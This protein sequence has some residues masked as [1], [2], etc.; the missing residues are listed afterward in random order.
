MGD[1]VQSGD[2]IW[3]SPGDPFRLSCS[4]Q[5][6]EKPAKSQTPDRPT[7]RRHRGC[8]P[9]APSFCIF[10]SG[11]LLPFISNKQATLAKAHHSI[12]NSI[13]P[14]FATHLGTPGAIPQAK[15]GQ[16]YKATP[17]QSLL[18]VGRFAL[19]RLDLPGAASAIRRRPWAVLHNPPPSQ[20]SRPDSQPP[21]F[22]TAQRGSGLP[23]SRF[24]L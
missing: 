9:R 10:L 24:M 4:F 22:P 13:N 6:T 17:N 7:R 11:P 1:S 15:K 23:L 12:V 8:P 18:A 3:S 2:L 5:S 20:D 19:F 16:R 14:F 21:R